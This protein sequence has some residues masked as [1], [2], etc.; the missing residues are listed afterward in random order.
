MERASVAVPE[1]FIHITR[2]LPDTCPP[3]V[4][5]AVPETQAVC[6]QPSVKPGVSDELPWGAPSH[7][8][9]PPGGAPES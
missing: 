2:L 9:A 6:D 1:R 7:A 5:D 4:G 3:G 8:L